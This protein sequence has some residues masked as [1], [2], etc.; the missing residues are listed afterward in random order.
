LPTKRYVDL[1]TIAAHDVTIFRDRHLT[2]R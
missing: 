2:G 1:E